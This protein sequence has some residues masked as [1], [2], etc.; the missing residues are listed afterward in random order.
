MLEEAGYDVIGEAADGESALVSARHLEPDVLLPDISG[1]V[2]AD[3]LAGLPR[4]PLVV[5]TSSRGAADLGE[6]A[7][8]AP[9]RGFLPKA[10]LSATTLA[11]ILR[12]AR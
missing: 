12:I 1:L 10:T 2:V 7:A 9:V 5:L 3:R 8:R 6:A 4:P 11:A